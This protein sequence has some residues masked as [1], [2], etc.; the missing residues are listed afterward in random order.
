M[1]RGPSYS[2]PFRQRGA[3][4]ILAAIF[5]VV[6]VSLMVVVVLN[7]AGSDINDTSMH[8]DAVE[9]LFIAETGVE[10]ASYLYANGTT[11]L[12]LTGASDSVGRGDFSITN[13]QLLSGNCRVR[14]EGTVTRTHAVKRTIEVDLQLAGG[15]AFAV[16][17]GG[18]ILAWN[19]SA[20]VTQT[21]PT[22]ENLTAIDCPTTSYCMAVG[23]AGTVLEWNGGSWSTKIQFAATAFSSVACL[24]ND[25]GRCY[26]TGILSGSQDVIEYWNGSGWS[27][28]IPSSTTGR[29]Y[30]A[31]ACNTSTCYAVSAS[32][33]FE[34]SNTT[35]WSWE[36][37]T[38]NQL[39]GIS[40]T[41]NAVCWAVGNGING[42]NAYAIY[43]R[44]TAGTWFSSNIAE[45]PSRDLNAVDCF[46]SNKCWAVGARHGN[47]Y[48]FA[49]RNGGNWRL[50]TQD[51][52]GGKTLNGVSCSSDSLCWAVGDSGRALYWDGADWDED[53]AWT[54]VST[55]VTTDLH[56]VYFLGSGSGGGGVRLV[57]WQEVVL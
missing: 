49:Y 41:S 47:K 31:V 35:S 21:S 45:N 16:G 55:G 53:N 36:S 10:H 15:G 50:S 24:E 37:S 20:W 23:S 18:L 28:T 2:Y 48:S 51:L 5:L 27:N 57:R 9:A 4:T 26:A 22:T 44:N 14:V 34:Q 12:A 6:S 32:G 25:P 42:P 3:A 17:D 38:G 11:C 33:R 46:A 1:T 39:N 13:A 56:D 54:V 7:M 8:S 30:Q 40:C 52:G 43:G 29:N 19:G